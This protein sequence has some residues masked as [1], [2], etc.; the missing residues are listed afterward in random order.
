M[1]SLT[2]I[3]RL[4]YAVGPIA[5]AIAWV[6]S[7]ALNFSYGVDV[8]GQTFRGFLFASIFLCI[9]FAQ[10]AVQPI[11]RKL[12]L[13]GEAG[14]AAG[15]RMFLTV[16]MMFSMWVSVSFNLSIRENSVK[17]DQFAVE[18]TNSQHG[19]FT[20]L[21]RER[22]SLGNPR[23]EELIKFDLGRYRNLDCRYQSYR[24]SCRNKARLEKE[25]RSRQRLEELN[26][27][28]RSEGTQI[29]ERGKFATT[30]I[31]S[32]KLAGLFSTTRERY[33]SVLSTLLFFITLVGSLLIEI[34]VGSGLL[35]Q[36]NR[37]DN[38]AEDELK[39]SPAPALPGGGDFP[40]NRKD[41]LKAIS[42]K[43]IKKAVSSS[44]ASEANKIMAEFFAAETT[45]IS[46]GDSGVEDVMDA[47]TKFSDLYEAYQEYCGKYAIEPLDDSVFS[48]RCKEKGLYRPV[49]QGGTAYAF[50]VVLKRKK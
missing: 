50:G 41:E 21:V 34:W 6:Y 13:E 31:L 29:L 33:Q 8:G 10:A 30:D 49:K 12:E 4:V 9:A 18:L 3:L 17:R 16:A 15:L 5:W 37:R 48:Q 2:A 20:N 23:G 22:R 19:N 1:D 35:W 44:N 38:M 7:A 14:I 36:L 40:E 26:Q 25:L 46:I 28:I 27:S 11:V 24:R 47:S 32:E 42:K 43:D 39:A 45:P